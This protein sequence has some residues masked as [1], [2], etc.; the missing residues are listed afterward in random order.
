MDSNDDSQNADLDLDE[1]PNPAPEVVRWNFYRMMSILWIFPS[2]A[3]ITILVMGEST[4]MEAATLTGK[5]EAMPIEKLIS[6][7]FLMIQV[8]FVIQAWRF[9]LNSRE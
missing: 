1:C 8:F 7:I 3:S 2:L 5:V 4:W 9:R 6:V